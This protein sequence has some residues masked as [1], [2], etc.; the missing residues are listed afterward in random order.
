MNCYL[1]DASDEREVAVAICRSCGAGLCR[2]H[3]DQE[4]VGARGGG[5]VRRC[6]H[7]LAVGAARSVE[8]RQR[9]GAPRRLDRRPLVP[10][11]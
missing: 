9:S 4:L 5:M 8:A 10:T 3:L 1:C 2:E 11:P 7:T 6:G